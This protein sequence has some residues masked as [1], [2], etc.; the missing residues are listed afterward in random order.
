MGL[1]FTREVDRPVAG[2]SLVDLDNVIG[3]PGSLSDNRFKQNQQ[4]VHLISDAIDTKEYDLISTGTDIDGQPQPSER[5]IGFI[6][7]DVKA[8]L[9][10][11]EWTNI[12]GAKPVKDNDI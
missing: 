8:A 12:V 5:R 3:H 6:A 11:E 1:A 10:S 9:Q 7:D 2:M 4:V